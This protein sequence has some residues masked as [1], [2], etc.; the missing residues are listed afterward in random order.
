[1]LSATIKSKAVLY[2]RVSSKEQEETGYSLPAQEKFL[3]EYAE[4]NNFNVEKVFSISESASGRMQRKIF[5]QMMS[6]VRQH[7]INVIIVETT[8]RLTRNFADVP[9]IDAWVLEDDNH[10]IHLAKESCILNKNSRS[11]EW[12]M[13]RVKVATA[14]YYV[15]LLSENVKKGQ[16]EKLAQGQLPQKPPLGYKTIGEKGKKVHVIDEYVAPLIRKIF[17]WYATGNYSLARLETELYKA[18]LRSKSGRRIGISWIHRLLSDP[19]YYGKIRWNGQTYQG[20]HEPLVS[21]DFFDKVQDLL[22]RKIQNPHFTKHNPIFKSKMHCEHCGGLVTW[23]IKKGHWYGHCNNHGQFRNCPAKTCI[24]QE[25]VEEQVIGSFD[26]LAPK[27]EEVLGWIE[28]I[29]RE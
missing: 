2:C 15:R 27:N 20:H 1:M 14:E 28:N 21:K 17:E 3:R 19:F 5:S 23:Y 13:W 10:Q 22:R 9:I 25:K 24:R 18:G 12:F 29:I 7:R 6:Y 26:I 8:D 16:K 11:H 4:K